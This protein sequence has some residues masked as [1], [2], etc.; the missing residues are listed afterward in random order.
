MQ[1]HEHLRWIFRVDPYQDRHV[2]IGILDKDA[3]WLAEIRRKEEEWDIRRA[4]HSFEERSPANRSRMGISGA[5]VVSQYGDHGRGDF[6][7]WRSYGSPVA[8]DTHNA[9]L[10]ELR[11]AARQM[12]IRLENRIGDQAELRPNRRGV[13]TLALSQWRTLAGASRIRQYPACGD[14][15]VPDDRN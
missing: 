1:A 11:I 7:L 6:L 15:P 13:I 10:N 9:D 2:A 8:E 4:L 3:V 12:S 5:D 14:S